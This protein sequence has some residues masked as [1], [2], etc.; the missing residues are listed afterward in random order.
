MITNSI[1]FFGKNTSALNKNTEIIVA[2]WNIKNPA[3]AGHIIRLGHNLNAK[4]I[5]FISK[6]SGLKT[7]KIKKTAGFSAEQTKWEFISEPDFFEKIDNTF[8]LVILETCEGAEN[9]FHTK[10]PGKIILLA[11]NETHGL[12][13]K[14]IEM[15]NVRV[16]IPMPGKCKSMNVSHAISVAGFEWFRQNE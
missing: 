16:Y 3:N 15:S 2:V 7:S 14:I 13:K 10:L 6:K 8:E 1:E 12:P 11:G 4:Q 5:Y 9:I